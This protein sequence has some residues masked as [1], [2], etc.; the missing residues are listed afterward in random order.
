VRYS[1]IH[2]TLHFDLKRN[3][4]RDFIRGSARNGALKNTLVSATER[5]GN[6]LQLLFLCHTDAVQ[7]DFD[8]IL[9]HSGNNSAKFF[10][11]LKLY[12]SME[13]WF[14]ENNLKEEVNLADS[15]VAETLELLHAC[16]P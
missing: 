14:H 1:H 8:T 3:G 12:I 10:N 6:M 16:F 7:K 4:E 13:E 9:C 5:C 15:L 2:H 11:C